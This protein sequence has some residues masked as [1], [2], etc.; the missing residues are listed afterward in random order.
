LSLGRPGTGLANESSVIVLDCT[1]AQTISDL[2]GKFPTVYLAR[3]NF[4]P[5]KFDPS[6]EITQVDFEV[7]TRTALR[8]HQGTIRSKIAKNEELVVYIVTSVRMNAFEQDA[9]PANESPQWLSD[10]IVFVA[11]NPG[12]RS[13]PVTTASRPITLSVVKTARFLLREEERPTAL[14]SGREEKASSVFGV[15]FKAATVHGPGLDGLSRKVHYFYRQKYRLKFKNGTINLSFE[16]QSGNRE[17]VATIL[18]GPPDHWFLT[19]GGP[20]L[21][22]DPNTAVFGGNPTGLYVGLNWTVNDIFDPEPR[23]LI[24]NFLDVNTSNPASA[25]GLIGLGIGLPKTNG[26]IPFSTLSVTEILTYNFDLSKFQFLTMLNYDVT[27][28]LQLV[29][30]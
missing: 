20:L 27:D 8:L 24:V 21:A 28:I 12:G 15:T 23:F 7:L 6:G 13:K 30:L 26:F 17:N 10:P 3:R 19:A 2:T 18:S 4:D 22:Y 11:P 5:S 25:F 14:E 1:H 9:A 29:K 16:D